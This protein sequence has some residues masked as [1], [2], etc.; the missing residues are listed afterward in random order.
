M[1]RG[2]IHVYTGNGKGKTTAA[3]GL[4]IRALGAGLKV[5]LVQ[6]LKKGDFSEIRFL[7]SQPNIE[8]R[9]FGTGKFVKGRPSKEDVE[10]AER[11]IKEI[12]DLLNSG[13]FDVVILDEANIAVKYGLIDLETIIDLIEARPK[14]TEIILTGRGADPKIIE[15]AD[16]VTEMQ[17]IKHY[18]K[19]G[20]YARIGIEK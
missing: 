3:L 12:K 19:K 10:E 9:Q 20:V 14:G 11:G 18:F 4:G 13:K 2:F 16:L 1:D 15:L 5:L 17:E 7:G 6:F 8:I